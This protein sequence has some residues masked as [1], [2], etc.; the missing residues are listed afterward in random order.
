MAAADACRDLCR[1]RPA[2]AFFF[3]VYDSNHLGFLASIL[4][5]ALGVLIFRGLVEVVVRS[6]IPWPSLLSGSDELKE[7]DIV[8]RRRF[9]YWRTSSAGC[10]G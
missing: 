7:D 8:A 4:I 10:A 9:W 2:P 3:V 5:T 1:P 6:I